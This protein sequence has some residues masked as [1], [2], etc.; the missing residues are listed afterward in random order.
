MSFSWFRKHEKTFLWITVAFTIVV[1]ALFSSMSDVE[2]AFSDQPQGSD[3]AGSFV[4][5]TT[6][7]TVTYDL[8]SFE[9]LGRNYA[10]LMRMSGASTNDIDEDQLWAFAIGLADAQ[11][12]GLEVSDRE[13][14]TALGRM[15]GDAQSYER[16]VQLAGFPSKR[17]FETFFRKF[18][19]YLRWQEA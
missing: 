7:E 19:V 4:C 8:R 15:M 11:G 2:R 13:L 10:K 18:L 5:A 6:G 1:F 3:V 16:V 17:A 9:T 12:A 14:G